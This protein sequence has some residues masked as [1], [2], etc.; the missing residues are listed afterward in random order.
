MNYEI[1]IHSAENVPFERSLELVRW[2]DK[3]FGQIPFL[4]AKPDWFV[5]ALSDTKLLGRVG[6][7]ERKVSFNGYL[8]EIAGISGVITAAECRGQGV[9]IAVLR[10][11]AEFIHTQLK[12]N[13]GLLLC[14]SQVALF[15][16]KLGWKIIDGPT[17]F[18]QPTGKTVF[19]RL[20]MIL[21]LGEK[22]WPG[23]PVDLCGLPW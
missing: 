19:P 18:D 21:E 14:R 7:V 13:Y 22:P 3:E 17:T 15:Y 6:I 4:W 5:L 2:F 20:T 11:A 8:L 16:E 10:S 23:G 1:K 12:I 9:G